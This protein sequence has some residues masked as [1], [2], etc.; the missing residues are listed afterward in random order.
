MGEDIH[1][2]QFE[3]C[4]NPQWVFSAF[5]ILSYAPNRGMSRD[6]YY[7]LEKKGEALS[8]DFS[9]DD[10]LTARARRIPARKVSIG[11]AGEISQEGNIFYG[12][13]WLEPLSEERGSWGEGGRIFCWRPEGV[14]DLRDLIYGDA[15]TL[16]E[17]NEI[18][19]QIKS[20]Y[21]NQRLNRIK[22]E[23][24]SRVIASRNRCR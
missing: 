15:T 18:N 23:Q 22:S 12:F 16:E 11:E 9:A 24:K 4:V 7:P 14:R 10:I 6:I 13:L 2:N 3:R 8:W 21:V 5:Y 1:F 19:A 17:I 20:G